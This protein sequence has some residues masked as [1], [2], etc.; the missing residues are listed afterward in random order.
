MR[1]LE[2][3]D[4]RL[5][6][7]LREDW[8]RGR[9]QAV[10]PLPR[11]ATVVLA[12]HRAAGKS[13]LL[14]KVGEALGRGCVDLDGELERRSGRFLREWVQRDEKGFRAAERD[15]F[16]EL[17]PGRVVAVGGGFLASHRDALLG[18]VVVLVPVS[19]ETYRE[20]LL[21]DRSRPRLRPELS[22]EDELKEI[23]AEREELHRAARPLS[24]VDFVLRLERGTRP[25]RVVT[26]PPGVDPHAF[27]WRARHLGADLLEVRTDLLP[28]ELQLRS[29][30]RALPLLVSQR[31]SE[32]PAEWLALASLVDRPL[33]TAPGEAPGP[34]TVVS[35]HADAP[36]SPGE[37]V[38]RWESVRPG[39]Q[40][41]HVEPL[42]EPRSAQRLFETRARL[43]QRFGADRVTVLATG[44]LA[45]P[46]RAVLARQNALDYLALDQG[47]SA[48]PGQRLLEDAAREWRGQAAEGEPERLGILGQGLAHSRSPRIHPQPFDRV[49]LPA[50]ADL[51]GLLGAL[52][53]HYRGFAVTTPFKQ[54]AA[55]AVRADAAAVNTLVRTAGGYRGAST[56]EAGAGAVLD[57]LG[58]KAVTVLGEGGVA[59]ALRAAAA[60]RG[61]TLTFLKASQVTTTGLSGAVVWTWPPSFP[62]PDAL[63]FSG[64]TVAVISYGAPG[65]GI[66]REVTERGGVPKRLGAR[67]FIAQAR[68]QRDLFA[69]SPP[70]G[71]RGDTR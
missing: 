6:A 53:P 23:Y 38:S 4:P 52:I 20:R 59:S 33:A 36:L 14:R 58:A 65:R 56:D 41:K 55:K 35:F 26:L 5:Q 34:R 62:P 8:A 31:T 66:V 22:V 46:F 42:G 29:A 57:A 13:T 69:A 67:W 70:S 43:V 10:D 32:V 54:R 28:A 27:A 60:S 48:A 61:V 30:S 37:A 44:P 64:A 40:V 1:F 39:S 16:L 51:D 19:F 9:G 63:R 18:C 17:P 68:A 49:E 47:F 71:E 3:I 12:G 25:R 24:L 50:D 2:D 7:G 11:G 21:G 15:C 45:L